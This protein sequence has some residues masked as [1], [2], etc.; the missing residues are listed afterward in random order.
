MWRASRSSSGLSR[1]SGSRGSSRGAAPA[2]GARRGARGSST[3]VALLVTFALLGLGALS[4]RSSH[5]D[6]SSAGALRRATQARYVAEVGLH[7]AAALMQQQGSY[8]MGLRRPGEALFVQ[9]DGLVRYA[10]PPLNL[11]DPYRP[12]RQV[13]GSPFVAL[14][15]GPAPLNLGPGRVPSYEVRVDGFADGGA[16]P[17]QE[18]GQSDLGTPRQRFCVMEFTA[19]GYVASTPLPTPTARAADEDAWRASLELVAEQQLKAAVVVGPF[20]I[21]SCAP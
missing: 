1:L 3:L 8:L 10:L 15:E 7:H 4:L 13:Q 21:S 14:S 2:R 9:S 12:Q 16:P 18:L 17:G 11:G 6:V 20:L 5:Q 19:T